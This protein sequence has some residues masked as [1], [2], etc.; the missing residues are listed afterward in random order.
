MLG[1]AQTASARYASLAASW[2]ALQER[3]EGGE[4]LSFVEAF[5]LQ[6][7]LAYA[8]RVISPAV[9]AGEIVRAARAADLGWQ[10]TGV[11]ETTA[12]LEQQASCGYGAIALRGALEA[13]VVTD[14]DGLLTLDAEMRVAL[15]FYGLA[16]D[17]A[18]CAAAAADAENSQF[19]RSLSIAGSSEI[20]RMLGHEPP[21]LPPPASAAP[22]HRLRILARLGEGGRIEHGVEL[23]GGEQVL[24]TVRYLPADA[25]VDEWLISSDVEVDGGL[26]GKI[27][28]RRLADGRVE[29]GFLSAVGE[30]IALDIRYLPADLP[31]GVWL[32]SG[33]IKVPPAATMLE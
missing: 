2:T 24:P 21:P 16:N 29:L 22:P 32:R 8:E 23:S 17:G 15:P 12:G 6:S 28:T 10:D 4:A 27:R 19:L 26:I 18:L 13:A 20:L 3:I 11:Q 30:R 33:E 5:A 25:P 14:V 9:T 7:Q 31:A 1:A